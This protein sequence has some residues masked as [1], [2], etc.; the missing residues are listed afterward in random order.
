M[1]LFSTT[2]INHGSSLQSGGMA[3]LV[4]PD[5]WEIAQVSLPDILR[6]DL[7][8]ELAAGR[9]TLCKTEDAEASGLGIRTAFM[10]DVG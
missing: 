9:A 5:A 4:E 7:L 2:W 10:R 6:V 3:D 8:G 1:P